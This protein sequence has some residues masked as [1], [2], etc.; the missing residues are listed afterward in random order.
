M[1]VA[2]QCKDDP[3]IAFI[4]QTLPKMCTAAVNPKTLILSLNMPLLHQSF[5]VTEDPENLST[6]SPFRNALREHRGWSLVG[7]MCV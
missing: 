7:I 4:L 1:E 3:Y 2:L 6:H 5:V